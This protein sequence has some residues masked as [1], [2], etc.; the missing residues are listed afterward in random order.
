MKIR[1]LQLIGGAIL[2]ACTAIGAEAATINPQGVVLVNSGNGFVQINGP[3][4]IKPGD[5]VMVN[6]GSAQVSY[7]SGSVANLQPGQ[8]YTIGNEIMTGQ[9]A[10]GVGG[11]G[12][13]GQLPPRG[14]RRR[15]GLRRGVERLEVE[16]VL[17]AAG[18]CIEPSR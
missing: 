13:G 17:R 15:G 14:F 6:E 18:S 5:M 16:R 9:I 1:T 4:Q 3:T 11:G 8:V 10:E 2:A 7:E 12:V